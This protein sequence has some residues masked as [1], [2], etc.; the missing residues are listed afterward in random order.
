LSYEGTLPTVSDAA[1]TYGHRM[2]PPGRRLRVRSHVDPADRRPVTV[3]ISL[4]V[5]SSGADVFLAADYSARRRPWRNIAS[6][7]TRN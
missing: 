5:S 1:E 3:H 6:P 4:R 2:T 7:R